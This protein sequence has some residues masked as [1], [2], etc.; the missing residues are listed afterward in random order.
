MLKTQT[1]P[2]GRQRIHSWRHET[3]AP[4]IAGACRECLKDNKRLLQ[5]MP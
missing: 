3:I 4:E 2:D 5:C 1:R